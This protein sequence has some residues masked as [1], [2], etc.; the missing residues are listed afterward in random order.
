MFGNF[1]V[2]AMIGTGEL[3]EKSAE[4]SMFGIDSSLEAT[5]LF[6]V[7]AALLSL[8]GLIS[9]Y[10]GIANQQSAD[11][12]RDVVYEMQFFLYNNSKGTKKSFE[13]FIQLRKHYYH[14]TKVNFLNFP[15][16]ILATST[17]SAVTV[18]W[19]FYS[20]VIDGNSLFRVFMRVAIVILF[21]F[22]LY[23]AYLG[24]RPAG[25]VKYDNFFHIENKRMGVDMRELVMRTLRL[26]F[27]VYYHRGSYTY[28]LVVDTILGELFKLAKNYPNI[29]GKLKISS[30]EGL[31]DFGFL[32]KS[33]ELEFTIN[34]YEKLEDKLD[35]LNNKLKTMNYF[36]IELE[37]KNKRFEHYLDFKRVHISGPTIEHRSF[38]P[39]RAI[40]FPVNCDSYQLE[41]K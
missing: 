21:L 40:L 31:R 33:G 35:D 38:I 19:Y 6:G 16:I 3:I 28:I 5:I 8:V 20:L 11:K 41:S 2:I 22:I 37:L 32:W 1:L 29:S 17:V 26:K 23:I 25:V 34:E 7:S 39:V 27:E 12:A 4:N 15:I 13:R 24:T 10:L 18:A 36:D 9:I 30:K 14:L